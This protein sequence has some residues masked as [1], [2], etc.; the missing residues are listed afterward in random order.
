[1]GLPDDTRTQVWK[2][3]IA[4]WRIPVRTLILALIIL[5]A[6]ASAVSTMVHAS[7]TNIVP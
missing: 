4:S 2:A 3:E 1:M 6:V 7:P 5:I